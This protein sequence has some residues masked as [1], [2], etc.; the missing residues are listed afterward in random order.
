MIAML[1]LRLRRIVIAIS[2]IVIAVA[3]LEARTGSSIRRF[4]QAG[5]EV[6]QTLFASGR[7]RWR[8]SRHGRWK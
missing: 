1:T 5:P 3:G 6:I 4:L 8:I 7:A 2:C